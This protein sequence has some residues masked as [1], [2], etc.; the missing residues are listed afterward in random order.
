MEAPERAALKIVWCIAAALI[1]ISIVEIGLYL[2]EGLMPKQPVPM[3]VFPF[4]LKSIPAVLGVVMLIKAKTVAEWISDK[5][6]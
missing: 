5:F 1:I 6:D 2:A 3:T 4:V